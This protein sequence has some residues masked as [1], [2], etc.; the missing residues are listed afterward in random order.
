MTS[1]VKNDHPRSRWLILLAALSLAVIAYLSL[2]FVGN[3]GPLLLHAGS[4]GVCH[5]WSAVVGGGRVAVWSE[6]WSNKPATT[7][8][9]YFWS[10]RAKFWPPRA[11]DPKRCFWEFD[12]HQVTST[13]TSSSFLIACPIWCV[14][15]PFTIAPLMWLK[16]RRQAAERQGFAVIAA[17]TTA[18]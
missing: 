14:A 10:W 6:H 9:G 16:R 3:T 13:P 18:T 12:A 4:N 2:G 7:P 17:P 8:L 11:P 5:R 15:L 1:Q